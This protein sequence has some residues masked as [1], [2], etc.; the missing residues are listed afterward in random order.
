MYQHAS[1]E[2]QEPV[3]SLAKYPKQDH[4]CEAYIPLQDIRSI[5]HLFDHNN[6]L[7]EY[8]SDLDPDYVT[9]E[10][11]DLGYKMLE[12]FDEFGDYGYCPAKIGTY[13]DQETIE[14]IVKDNYFT[15]Y[16]VEADLRQDWTCYTEEQMQLRISYHLDA[17]K[18]ESK[19]RALKMRAY[20]YSGQ[21]MRDAL[22]LIKNSD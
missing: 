8:L 6:E 15:R 13:Y 10:E 4:V 17:C 18:N 1:P 3:P 7:C 9:K 20:N 21:F 22:N 19:E 16:W 12:H 2:V 14:Q 5:R 11:R